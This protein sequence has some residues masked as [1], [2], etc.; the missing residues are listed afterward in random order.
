MG[1]IIQDYD[2][3]KLFPALG[4]GGKLP[5]GVVSHEFFLNGHPTNPYCERVEG[6]LSA[7]VS[8]LQNVQ[9][10]GPTNFSPVINHVARFASESATITEGLGKNYFVLLIITDG[11]I[12]DMAETVGAIVRASQ[13]P[14]SIIIVGESKNVY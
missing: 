7:Y 14:M 13:L 9:L 2:S 8:S 3:D 11:I 12:T 1:E 4:F 6:I 5:N 10:Y